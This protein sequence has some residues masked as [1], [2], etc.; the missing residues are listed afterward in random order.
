[1]KEIFPLLAIALLGVVRPVAAA[2]QSGDTPVASRDTVVVPAS[3]SYNAGSLHRRLLG[4]NYRDLW[5]TPMRVPVLDLGTFAGGLHPLK[6]GGGNQT[7]SL[8]LANASGAEYVFRP[9]YKER[10]T[11]LDGFEGT[12]VWKIFSDQLSASHPAGPL[13][14]APVMEAGKIL[15]VTPALVVMPDDSALGKFRKD[16]AGLLGTI[17]AYPMVVDDGPAFANAVEIIDSDDLL[18]KL[19][20]SPD[21]QIDTRTFLSARLLD[22]FLND[23]DRHP[24]QWKW[25]KLHRDSVTSWEPIPR[26]RDKVFVSYEGLLLGAARFV[27]PK[28]VTFDATYPNLYGLSEINIDFDRRVLVGLDAAVWDSVARSLSRALTDSVIDASLRAMPPEYAS[29]APEFAR[30][31]RARRDALPDAANKYYHKLFV[32][33]DVHATDAEDHV[34][35]LRAADGVLDVQIRSKKGASWFER[36]FLASETKEVRLY[37]HGG[38]DVAVVRGSARSN[39]TIRIIGGPGD[40][41][42]IDSSRTDAAQRVRLYENGPVPEITDKADTLKGAHFDPDTAWNRIPWYKTFR[43]KL[44]PPSRDHGLTWAPAAGFS[45]GQGLGIVPR[46][47]IVRTQ[48]GFRT[49][50]YLSR[51]QIDAAYAT[52][53]GGT[54]IGIEGDRRFEETPWHILG[55]AQSSQL[56]VVE[57]HGFGNDVPEIRDDFFEVQQRQLSI[58]PAVG[59]TIWPTTEISLGPIAKYVV[60]DSISDRYISEHVPYGAGRFAQ[61]GL[62]LALTHD[63]R[64]NQG[65]PHR[66]FLVEFEASAYPGLWDAKKAFESISGLASTYLTLPIGG[67]RPVLALRGGGKKVFGE[68][69]YYES[70]FVGSRTSLRTLRS[71]Q[72]AGDAALY[73]TAELRVPVARFGLFLP[74]NVGL[75]GFTDVGRVYVKGDSPGGWHSAAG[76]GLWLGILRPSMGVTLVMTNR[77]ARRFVAGL[78][79]NY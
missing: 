8:R 19:N 9:L 67:T 18:K 60:T 75:L 13:I 77:S 7:R 59:F 79:F 36:R 46:V 29:A 57:F 32:Y 64:D 51:I 34:E 61:A 27:A 52:G 10:L 11:N 5:A 63:S 50:P 15:H 31:A 33:A 47:G 17:E 71:Q 70:A 68:F 16:F 40:N 74:W 14:A 39:V 72:F 44:V 65:D 56:E 12:I 58:H 22:I 25:A 43:G 28:L 2:A 69:P 20:K 41:T 45:S 26:D 3:T 30:K 53:T 37:L 62:Q 55:S 66:G 35:V 54:R 4:D 78:G 48:Y 24:G 42:L 1:M 38:D 49:L 76:G 23:N 6:E 21:N 73:G